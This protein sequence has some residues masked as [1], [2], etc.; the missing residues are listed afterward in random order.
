MIKQL[1]G[2][3][4]TI[5]KG[6]GAFSLVK[7]SRWRQQRLLILCY[8]GVAL[9]D[10]DQWRPLLY[11]SPKRLEQRL[12]I[13]REGKY[14]VLPLVEGLQRLYRKD[15][16]PR[17]VVLTFDDGGYDFYKKAR[18]LLQHYGFP[19][20]VYLTT[21]YS[22]LQRPIFGLICSYM[23]WKARNTGS[24]DLNEFGIDI[25]VT[26]NSPE[27]REKVV[28]H[29]LQSVAE[30]EL[31]GEQE[32]LIAARLA[33]RLGINYMG[34]R[35]KR[36]LQLMK[37]EEVI[38]LAAEG[39]D[40]QLHTHRHRTPAIEELFR[41]EIRDNRASI[42]NAVASKREHFCYPSGAYRPE[43]LAWLAKEEVVS[44]TTCDTGFA[45]P[46]S[47]P[48][49]LPRLVDTSSRTDLEFEGWLSGIGHFL[50]RRRLGQL[51]YVPD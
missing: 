7:D 26:L 47:P 41:R 18:P 51:A 23:L 22:E 32:D 9:E 11:M 50:S 31:N 12:D 17:S 34:L 40:F 36:I 20:T 4:L 1:R 49:L 46:A 30:Q 8:H 16:P 27:A 13:L 5:L 25:P 6:T 29:L 38:Q 45:T 28:N 19:A 44:A 39:V 33:Q 21:Y 24:V 10:E 2:V 37:R 35:Q 15:L 3:V 42:A 43:F 48:L 14:T